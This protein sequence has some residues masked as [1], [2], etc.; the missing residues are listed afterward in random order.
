[1]LSRQFLTVKDVAE[2]LKIGEATVR[3]W[4]RAGDLRAIDVGREWRVAPIDL[5]DFLQRH[6]TAP[7]QVGN[8][9]AEASAQDRN[10]KG[11]VSARAKRD[12]SHSHKRKS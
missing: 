3:H 1:M 12:R 11:A 9:P 6:Q 4:I 5:E 10:G 7:Q 2:L 8:K